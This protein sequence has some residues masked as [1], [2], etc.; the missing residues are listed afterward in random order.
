MPHRK[1]MALLICAPALVSAQERASRQSR[2]D[3]QSYQ[4]DAK[5][6]PHAQT[7]A[8]IAKVKFIPLEDTSSVAFELNNALNVAKVLDEDGREIPSSR[9]AQDMQVRLT[10]PQTL[11]KGKP[12]TITFIYDGKLSGDEDSPVFGI[13]FAAIHPDFAFLLYPSRWFPVNDYTID[14]FS[15]DLKVTVPPGFKVV[16]AGLDSTEAAAD[17]MTTF[18]FQFNQPS[19]PGDFAVVQASPQPMTAA[20]ITTT[21]YFRKAASMAQAYGAEFADAVTYFSSLYGLPPKKDLTVVETEDGA[22]KGYSAPG[23]V[24]LSPGGIGSQVDKKLVAN[25]V[26]RQWWGSLLSP[27]SRNNMWIENGMA[28]YSEILMVEHASGAGAMQSE[29]HDTY[30]EALTVTDPP[31]IQSGRLEDYSPEY[32]AATGGKGAAVFNMLRNVMGDDKFFK[33]M[34]AI[35]AQF[36]WKSIGSGDFEKLA[37]QFHGDSLQYFINEWID[38]SGAP[39]FK[40]EYTIFRTQKGFRVMGK[41]TQ[42]L[43]TFRMPVDLVIETEG[44]PVTKSIDVMGTSSE[45]SIDAY[46]KPKS[47]ALDP[48][49]KVLRLSDQMR[50]AVAIKRGEQFMAIGEYDNALREYQKGLDVTQNSSLAHYRIGEVFFAQG[51]NQA[52]ANSFRHAL[53][54]DLAPK[55]TEVWSHIYLGKIY[56]VSDQRDRAV[57][58]YRQALRTKDDS[59]GALEEASK[60]INQ[61][62]SRPRD[63]N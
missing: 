26:A 1:W 30:V 17:G 40:M 27:N 54:G 59:Y 48:Q 2:L 3:V 28:R 4:I 24:F 10:L 16:A 53:D 62:F 37:E 36:T 11:Q 49:E 57:N 52:A 47:V 46:G 5:I 39:E 56:D 8:A 42:D 63:T 43:D 45:F 51:N 41:V 7:L 9:V 55:W 25:E 6:D 14:R 20:G 18:R 60:Y 29:V 19:F 58:E 12:A 38:S 34:Q 50:V 32:W 21:F 15:S 44:S 23:L 22:P 31:L 35:P 33:L 61:K 13:K